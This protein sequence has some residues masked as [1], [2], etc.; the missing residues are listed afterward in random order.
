M[1]FCIAWTYNRQDGERQC[2]TGV[3]KVPVNIIG[4]M[5]HTGTIQEFENILGIIMQWSEDVLWLVYKT[6]R[7]VSEHNT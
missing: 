3:C 1:A 6:C 2:D 5:I 4:G 7:C